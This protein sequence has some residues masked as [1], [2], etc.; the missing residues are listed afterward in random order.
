MWPISLDQRFTFENFVVGQ[1]NRLAVAA[2][3]RVSEMPGSAYNPLFIYSGSGLGK[4]HLL[5]AIGHHARKLHP[6]L[7]IV[8]D[9]LAHFLGD[10]LE[11]IQAGKRDE[12][13]AN[14]EQVGFLLLD[15]VQF[16]AE[17]RAMQEELLRAWDVIL[18]RGGQVVLA[19]DRPPNEINDLDQ[20]VLS[21]FSGGLIADM[22]QPDYETRVAIVNRKATEQ[23]QTL[24]TGVAEAL[25]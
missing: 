8:Y 5:N 19:S 25:A 24:E 14:V 18:S 17:H 15:D 23:G 2:G 20:R 9:T 4:T 13:R 7:N 22:S 6:N 1:A 16:L 21:R 10:A 12:L 11:L 3:R